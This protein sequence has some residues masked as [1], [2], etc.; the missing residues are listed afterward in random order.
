MGT[1]ILR[2][3]KA[4]VYVHVAWDSC[5][6]FQTVY[7]LE[8][9][10]QAMSELTVDVAFGEQARKTTGLCPS[11]KMKMR[12]MVDVETGNTCKTL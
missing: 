10:L 6:D 5:R 2:N 1:W 3:R 11:F 8:G 9:K 4:S 7:N 12:Q